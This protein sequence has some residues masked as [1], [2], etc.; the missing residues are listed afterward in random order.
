LG[1][2]HP[3]GRHVHYSDKHYYMLYEKVKQISLYIHHLEKLSIDSPVPVFYKMTLVTN[4]T[5]PVGTD[6]I[7]WPKAPSAT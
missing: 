6:S 2:R 7:A 3:E 5:F 4:S 1:K